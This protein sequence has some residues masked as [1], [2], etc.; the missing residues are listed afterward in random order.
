MDNE[1]SSHFSEK[2]LKNHRLMNVGALSAA[3]AHDLNNLHAGMLTLTSL[4]KKEI[5]QKKCQEYVQTIEENTKRA[6][7]LSLSILHYLKGSFPQEVVSNP[8]SCIQSMAKLAKQTLP[9]QVS[10][11]LELP[12]TQ[13]S[14]GIPQTELCQIFLNLFFN[15]KEAIKEEGF[16][17]IRGTYQQEG[18]QGYFVLEVEDSGPGISKID[19]EKIFDPYFST[20]ATESGSGLG[21]SIVNNIVYNAKGKLEVQTG[22]EKSTKFSV[23]LPTVD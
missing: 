21:L 15:A 5:P 14:I 16:I 22:P 23:F 8:L 11:H 1:S 12:R 4:L 10:F 3:I 18:T 2:E 20:K 17:H 19:L 13:K 7:Q 6:S 9:S